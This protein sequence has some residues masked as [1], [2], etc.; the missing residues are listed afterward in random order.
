M[1][2]SDVSYITLYDPGQVIEPLIDISSLSVG[3]NINGTYLR[4]LL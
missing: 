3:V 1:E 2:Y 4:R